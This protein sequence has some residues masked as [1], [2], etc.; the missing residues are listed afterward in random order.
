M[1]NVRQKEGEDFSKA[2]VQEVINLLE[3]EKPITKKT[4]C[5][6][7]R[8]A[9]Y[10]TTRLNNIIQK[11]KDEAQSLAIRRKANRSKP[12]QKYEITTICEN[13]LS[14]TSLSELSDNL[15]RSTSIIKRVLA[16]HN[17]PLRHGAHSYNNPPLI[18]DNALANDYEKG[19]LVFAARYNSIATIMGKGYIDNT[20][21]IVYPIWV[22]GDYAR[23]A[24]QP[25]YELADLRDLQKEYGIKAKDMDAAYI[26][27]A[28][29]A[30]VLAANKGKKGKIRDE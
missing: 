25:W 15:A 13:Y 30:A 3:A 18:E 5:D 1:A 10:N 22:S 6:M 29:N 8:M 26:I 17:I 27:Y 12:I 23:S 4:A 20:H 24:Y 28:V 21:G 16:Q 14:G 19:D 11:H 9:S 2:R 7:L